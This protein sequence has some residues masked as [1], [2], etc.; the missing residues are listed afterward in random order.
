MFDNVVDFAGCGCALGAI[1]F[2]FSLESDEM[3]GVIFRRDSANAVRFTPSNII[4]YLKAPF[5][6]GYFWTN[7]NFWINNWIIMTSLGTLSGASTFF[8]LL[9]TRANYL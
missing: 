1:I 5:Q 8:A 7:S 3:G 6:K 9:Y 4:L 2:L